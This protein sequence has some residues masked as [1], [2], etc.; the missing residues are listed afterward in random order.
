MRIGLVVGLAAFAAAPTAV[1]A[2]SISYVGDISPPHTVPNGATS[3]IEFNVVLKKND[4]GKRVPT[5]VRHFQSRFVPMYCE[6]G[7]ISYQAG[8]FPHPTLEVPIKRAGAHGRTTSRGARGDG[9]G[10]RWDRI[11]ARRACASEPAPYRR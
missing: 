7:T 5:F 6:D 8:F 11:R 10:W 1:A 4:K 3:A 9:D 2:S